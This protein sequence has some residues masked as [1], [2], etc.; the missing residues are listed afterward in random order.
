MYADWKEKGC[1]RKGTSSSAPEVIDAL[2]LKKKLKSGEV[3]VEILNQCLRIDPEDGSDPK[4]ESSH[5]ATTP[6]NDSSKL[7]PLK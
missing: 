6:L 5:N 3:D 2:M 1:L 7:P 4:F